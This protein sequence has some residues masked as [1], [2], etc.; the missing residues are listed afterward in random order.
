MFAG[1]DG[2]KAGWIAV[3]I[4]GEEYSFGIY[5]T[6]SDLMEKNISLKRVLIDIPIGLSS[7]GFPRTIDA[8]IRKELGP[9]GSTVFNA[10]CRA[11]VY[12]PDN[13]RARKKNLQVE[14]KSLSIQSLN[15][16]NKIKEVDE[17]FF[18]KCTS[19]EIIESHPELCFKYLNKGVIV[20]SKKS[21]EAGIDERL[22]ILQSFDSQSFELY[23]KILSSFKRKD[24]KKDDIVDAMCLCLVNKLGWLEKLNFLE[25]LNQVDEKGIQMRIG[26]Y[27]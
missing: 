20:L 7:I 13:E 27:R 21:T 17:F 25:D 9:R 18:T 16:R 4:K 1:V 2:C 8:K 3:F 19:F 14:G 24:A 15:I 10:P 12:E 5:K 26:F 6:F 22:N 11:A 23:N